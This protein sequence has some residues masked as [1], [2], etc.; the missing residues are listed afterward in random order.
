MFSTNFWGYWA[1][2]SL[3]P[4]TISTWMHPSSQHDV[5]IYTPKTQ[6]DALKR[7][8]KWK[9]AYKIAYKIS[10]LPPYGGKFLVL[11]V[12]ALLKGNDRSIFVPGF[13]GWKIMS[14]YL[15]GSC[16]WLRLDE[17]L[18]SVLE[19]WKRSHFFIRISRLGSLVVKLLSKKLYKTE[20][21]SM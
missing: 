14:K 9:F 8:W 16:C 11:S 10:I 7:K 21:L 20:I 3:L 19:T 6:K 4:Q 15:V 2:I 12:S 13:R 1:N 5:S 17:G 18:S